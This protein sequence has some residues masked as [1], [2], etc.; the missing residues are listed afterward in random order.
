MFVYTDWRSQIVSESHSNFLS[1][2]SNR[3]VFF[4]L[5]GNTVDVTTRLMEESLWFFFAFSREINLFLVKSAY[6]RSTYVSFGY[7]W[8]GMRA[9]LTDRRIVHFAGSFFF[10]FEG[11]MF[12]TP[13]YQTVAPKKLGLKT[14]T[15]Q[16][17]KIKMIVACQ[18]FFC[19]HFVLLV[20]LLWF[21]F[22]VSGYI[23][24]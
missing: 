10:C 4:C 1:L 13:N 17:D 22:P 21:P 16:L 18:L 11:L 8:N 15:V 5:M 12:F 24:R 7:R 9:S 6:T 14:A 2:N 23:I 20:L 19:S 3:F